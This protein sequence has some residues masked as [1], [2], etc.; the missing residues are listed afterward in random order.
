MYCCMFLKEWYDLKLRWKVSDYGGVDRIYVPST[1]IWLPDIVLYNKLW[2]QIILSVYH[3]KS[4]IAVP[5]TIK[6]PQNAR[7]LCHA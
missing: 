1:L 5:Y 4:T 6:R 3:S 7:T 2:G